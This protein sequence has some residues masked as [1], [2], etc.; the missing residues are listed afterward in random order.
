MPILDSATKTLEETS[1]IVMEVYNIRHVERTLLFHEMCA[2]LET[3]GF[4]VFNMVDPLQR[5]FDGA[6]WQMDLFFARHDNPI[7]ANVTYKGV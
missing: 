3:K 4:R 2:L 7:F 6:L 1:Y 5:P